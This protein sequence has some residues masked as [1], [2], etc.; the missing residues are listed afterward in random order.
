MFQENSIFILTQ[1]AIVN[2]LFRNKNIAKLKHQMIKTIGLI[3]QSILKESDRP[4]HAKDKWTELIFFYIL[5][6]TKI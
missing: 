4:K 2:N 6:I 1:H 3:L 5:K